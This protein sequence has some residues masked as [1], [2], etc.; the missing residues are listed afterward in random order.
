MKDI[1]GQRFGRLTV[2]SRAPN[3]PGSRATWWNCRCDCG[4]ERTLIKSAL[5]CNRTKSC[6]CYARETASQNGK[7]CLRDLTGQVFGRLC[8]SFRVGTDPWG[9]AIWQCECACGNS[10]MVGGNHLRVG[11]TT[12]CGCL[13]KE[14]QREN[15]AKG[16]PSVFKDL[17]ALVFGR[18][19][20][21][22]RVGTHD[23]GEPLWSC[24]CQCGSVAIVTGGNLRSGNTKS[25]GCLQ[26]ESAVRLGHSRTGAK[27]PGWKG[28][29]T[30]EHQRIRS[31]LKYQAW[32]KAVFERDDYTCQMCGTK[33]SPFNAD[34]IKKFADYP[35]LRFDLDN[36]RTLC[37]PCH[38]NTPTYGNK[39]VC[40]DRQDP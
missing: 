20:V 36:G 13:V 29:V 2:T 23:S 31:S 21:V 28:G 12:S 15:L 37:E 11:D 40:E 19:T 33:R 16:G 39:R 34:H 17:T 32:R 30:P 10:C 18:L 9:S 7:S 8:V 26:S 5:T 22:S 25:C 14:K 1:A 24:V 27:A 38:K 3:R 4:T 35:E 6:G